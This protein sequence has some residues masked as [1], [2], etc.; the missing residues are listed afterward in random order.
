[1]NNLSESFEEFIKHSKRIKVKLGKGRENPHLRYKRDGNTRKL[2]FI[3]DEKKQIVFLKEDKRQR[4][5]NK[6]ELSRLI[7]KLEKLKHGS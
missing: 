6:R 5:Y 3:N 2:Y 1:M 7:K 4:I